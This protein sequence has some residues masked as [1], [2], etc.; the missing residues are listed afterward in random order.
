MNQMISMCAAK[1][2]HK[3]K[4]PPSLYVDKFVDLEVFSGSELAVKTRIRVWI[5][6]EQKYIIV[7]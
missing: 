4:F 7:V 3:Q 6:Y 1:E 5:I 2:A